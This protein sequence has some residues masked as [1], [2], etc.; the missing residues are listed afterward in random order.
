MYLIRLDDAS[1]YMDNNKW[2]KVFDILSNYSIKPIIGVIPNNEDPKLINK[3]KKNTKFWEEVKNWENNGMTIC[4][5]GYNHLYTTKCKGINPVGNKSEFAG[6]DIKLQ[7]DKIRKGTKIFKDKNIS[8]NC[9]FAP[10]H[11]YDFNTLSAIK[12]E[13]KINIIIDTL[14]H[15]PY[16][17]YGFIFIPQQFG[18]FRFSFFK[19]TLFCYHPNTMTDLDFQYFEFFLS[20][21][22]N[23]FINLSMINFKSIKK[24]SLFVLFIKNFF[25]LIHFIYH[26]IKKFKN[27][28]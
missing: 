12:E 2:I 16:R 19:T 25:Y 11:T 7:R 18:K 5:H 24:V 9:F 26:G 3:Y 8:T 27:N 6:V 10:S 4:M 28:N 22:K 13:S 21:N 17:Q 14:A 15:K 23:K 1:E 20:R